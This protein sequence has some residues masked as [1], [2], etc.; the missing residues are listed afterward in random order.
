[1]F[2]TFCWPNILNVQLLIMIWN[3][4]VCV[5]LQ[6]VYFFNILAYFL[7]FSPTCLFY[8]QLQL[9]WSPVFH[10]VHNIRKWSPVHH[11]TNK[12]F[13]KM[14]VSSI[15]SQNNVQVVFLNHPV[16]IRAP[17]LSRAMYLS[18]RN[19]FIKF[20]SCFCYLLLEACE[21]WTNTEIGFW[22]EETKI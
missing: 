16:R 22:K 8:F 10:G 2:N 21:K 14:L 3:F 9:Y 6:Q 12:M 13:W 4:K 5:L 17:L 1:M 15:F 20:Y 11:R 7:L 18:A 19:S